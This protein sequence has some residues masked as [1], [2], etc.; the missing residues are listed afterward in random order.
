MVSRHQLDLVVT[1]LGKRDEQKE[2]EK[3]KEK[4]WFSYHIGATRESPRG[5]PA[6]AR[7]RPTISAASGS[8]FQQVQAAAS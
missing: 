4:N 5:V 1:T 7:C 6:V 8:P 3:K 2:R